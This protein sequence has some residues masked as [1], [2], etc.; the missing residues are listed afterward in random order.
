MKPF[1]LLFAGQGSQNVGM[2]LSAIQ[3]TPQLQTFLTQLQSYA[4]F[5]LTG[6]LA[7]TLPGLNRTEYTQPSLVAAS[8]LYFQQLQMLFP[9]VK[10]DFYLG[11][12]LGEYSALY[13]SGHLDLKSLFHLLEIRA[14]AM[15]QVSENQPGMMAAIL[16]MEVSALRQLCA[17]HSRADH[18]VMIANYNAPGQLVISGHKEAVKTVMNAALAQGAK[19][20][21]ALNVSGAF[22]TPLMHPASEQIALALNQITLNAAHTPVVFN[23][24]G[25]TLPHLNHLKDYLIHQV[26]SP[27]MFEPSIRY[28][29]KQGIDHFVEIGPGNV[30]MGLVKK[31]LP[32]A[33]VVSYNGVQDLKHVKE[34]L[35]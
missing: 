22:H 17:Q 33:K 5:D 15:A 16:G 35:Q 10:P 21:I 29:A 14:T 24:T 2:G 3:E 31:I 34:L 9:E 23:W 8:L 6:I 28:L 4:H 1:A 19:R 11:F 26:K 30:L 20:A 7:G 18:F 25:E 13:A 12:S 27:V 32:E